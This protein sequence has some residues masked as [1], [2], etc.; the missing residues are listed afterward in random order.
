M[1]DSR[2]SAFLTKVTLY[3]VLAHLMT[4][5]IRNVGHIYLFFGLLEDYIEED[6][7]NII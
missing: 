4:T 2:L 1:L 5:H 3:G 6:V 7:I